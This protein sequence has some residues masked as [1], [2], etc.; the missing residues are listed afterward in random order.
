MS[1]TI[2][3]GILF[4]ATLCAFSL[5][6]I[7]PEKPRS[8]DGERA[9]LYA[10]INTLQNALG[11]EDEYLRARIRLEEQASEHMNRMFSSRTSDQ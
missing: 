11:S 10:K 3:L 9:D 4:V 7:I 2:C 6:T 1:V 5:S 8:D